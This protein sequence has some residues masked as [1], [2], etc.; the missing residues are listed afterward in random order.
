MTTTNY[1]LGDFL[2]RIKNAGLA[3]RDEVLCRNTKLIQSVAES[4]KKHGYI[5][6]VKTSEGLISVKLAKANKKPILMDLKLISRPGLRI[7]KNVSDIKKRKKGSS[8]LFLS[9]PKGILTDKE[10]LKENVGGEI[11]VEV[12]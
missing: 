12:W 1:S 4:L 8:V 3:G 10:A 9:T 7:Y 6:E 5:S 2:I 11:L